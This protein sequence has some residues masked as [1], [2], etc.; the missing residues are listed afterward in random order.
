LDRQ[1]HR[2]GADRLWSAARSSSLHLF[3]PPAFPSLPFPLPLS[4][5]DVLFLVLLTTAPS[6][7]AYLKG[8]LPVWLTIVL[9]ALPISLLHEL[10]HDLIHNLYFKK[11]QRSA[12]FPTLQLFMFDMCPSA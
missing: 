5:C 2:Y 4:G 11:V 10:E 7:A 12:I 9:M 8:L 1:L 6:I 3:L